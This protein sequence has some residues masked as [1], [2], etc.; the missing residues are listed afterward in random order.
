MEGRIPHEERIR[1]ALDG[2]KNQAGTGSPIKT[3]PASA[4][5]AFLCA[6]VLELA[7]RCGLQPRA[8]SGL[9]GPIPGWGI[10]TPNRNVDDNNPTCPKN[11]NLSVQRV[12]PD[13]KRKDSSLKAI[14]KSP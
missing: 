11:L 5:S 10:S 14:R 12:N 2:L 1:A 7:D 3:P 4:S 9:P 13:P 6:P 8:H